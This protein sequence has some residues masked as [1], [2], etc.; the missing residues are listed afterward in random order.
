MNLNMIKAGGTILGYWLIITVAILFWKTQII[1]PLGW[2]LPLSIQ[3][4]TFW[5]LLSL[6]KE[7]RKRLFSKVN[8]SF[9]GFGLWI[10]FC[11]S[12]LINR[13]KNGE[14]SIIQFAA[15]QLPIMM[16][17][18]ALVWFLNRE[19]V[20]KPKSIHEFEI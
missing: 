3:I 6:Y 7:T 18:V 11:N 9:A 2:I 8:G 16:S 1:A 15:Y 17:F 13:L 5:L 10:G 14:D 19:E 12:L 20:V 4:V